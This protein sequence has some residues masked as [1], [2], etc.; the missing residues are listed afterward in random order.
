M[1]CRDR[2]RHCEKNRDWVPKSQ[3]YHQN[4][5]PYNSRR[6]RFDQ[7]NSSRY[8]HYRRD[9]SDSREN[10]THFARQEWSDSPHFSRDNAYDRNPH[11]QPYHADRTQL[12]N[13]RDSRRVQFRT[14]NTATINTEPELEP[15]QG[16][17]NDNLFTDVST[18]FSEDPD[19]L[20]LYSP[21]SFSSNLK[22]E[23]LL[24]FRP[25]SHEEVCCGFPHQHLNVDL[26][27][28]IHPTKM[29]DCGFWLD[30]PQTRLRN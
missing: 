8:N 19:L 15:L 3:E 4:T 16:G 13:K 20:S 18:G 30:L 29:E 21:I 2:I 1:N 10:N 7:P 6:S 28:K 26:I 24:E 14:A 5:D 17:T 12:P 23:E 27:S 9:H 22:W 25:H 11:N